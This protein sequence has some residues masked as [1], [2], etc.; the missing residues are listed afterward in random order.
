MLSA[1]M[2]LLTDECLPDSW[3][4]YGAYAGLFAMLS[5]LI[6]QLIEVVANGRYRLNQRSKPNPT[7][8][9]QND[10]F[11]RNDQTEIKIQENQAIRSPADNSSS[12]N[13]NHH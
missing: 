7:P 11:K 9:D 8:N 3:N 6:M 4:V 5:A 13:Y 12:T 10:E 2:K 1:G